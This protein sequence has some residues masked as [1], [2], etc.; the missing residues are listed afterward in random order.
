MAKFTGHDP[1]LVDQTWKKLAE[2]SP[3]VASVRDEFY[4]LAEKYESTLSLLRRIALEHLPAAECQP[5]DPADHKE[6]C[7]CIMCIPGA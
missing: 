1:E 4:A 7:L 5:D 2:I 3:D 6:F